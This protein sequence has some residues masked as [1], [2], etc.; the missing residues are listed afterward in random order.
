MLPHNGSHGS[1][2]KSNNYSSSAGGGN[3]QVCKKNSGLSFLTVAATAARVLIWSNYVQPDWEGRVG[4]GGLSAGERVINTSTAA[5]V[6]AIRSAREAIGLPPT[7][8]P[9]L[10]NRTHHLFVSPALS[11][12]MGAR[13][14][15]SKKNQGVNFCRFP[16]A[17]R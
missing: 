13:E 9:F 6:S 3:S 10:N 15:K 14:M 7:N 16:H 2:D 12:L 11:F 5:T 17:L 8:M 4:G 1:G